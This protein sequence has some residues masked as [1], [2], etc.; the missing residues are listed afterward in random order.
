MYSKYSS[1]QRQLNIYG[2]TRITHGSDKNCYF[3]EHFLRGQEHLLHKIIRIP[4]K[5]DAPSISR[6]LTHAP[7]FNVIP[8]INAED[9]ST[10]AHSS[11]P[12]ATP[13]S[14][15]QHQQ[16]NVDDVQTE[17]D[18]ERRIKLLQ[19]TS[20]QI[21]NETMQQDGSSR[22]FHDLTLNSNPRIAT[23]SND[24]LILQMLQNRASMSA[25]SELLL[26]LSQ[27]RAQVEAPIQLQTAPLELLRQQLNLA[28]TTAM[29]LGFSQ[30]H[31]IRT[32]QFDP[33]SVAHNSI[34]SLIQ[35]PDPWNQARGLV[36]DHLRQIRHSDQLLLNQIS[37]VATQ[38]LQ[39]QLLYQ[40][41]RHD[42]G[43]R[44]NP[45]SF[46]PHAAGGL[47]RS[48]TGPTGRPSS[49]NLDI[50]NSQQN[51]QRSTFG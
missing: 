26:A 44:L 22:R 10:E 27:L 31:Q 49:D 50:T 3:H 21:E 40:L 8:A 6:D 37:S 4:T 32:S 20:R 25:A 45:M 1:F 33:L 47:L 38:S 46:L 36:F 11:L 13:N 29:P 9:S 18:V 48:V 17:A 28:S 15:I 34:A 14:R 39:N 23:T 42:D 19:R 41:N 35:Q 16:S 24:A 7:A 2:F 5:K 30:I 12:I 51:G 43:T